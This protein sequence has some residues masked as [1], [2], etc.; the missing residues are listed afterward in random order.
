MAGL[1][2]TIGRSGVRRRTRSGRR[3]S[4]VA[5]ARAA[6]QPYGAISR[7][8]DIAQGVPARCT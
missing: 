3:R 6:F 5:V 1:G 4:P 2:V 8:L 7:H